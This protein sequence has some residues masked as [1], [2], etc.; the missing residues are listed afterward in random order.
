[1]SDDARSFLRS[2]SL[3]KVLLPV[4]IGL[5]ITAVL[6]FR[7][8]D[9]SALNS[10]TWT[11]ASTLWI[12]LAFGSVVVRDYAYMVRI[13]HLTERSLSW[14]RSFVVIM[15]WEF[16]SALAPGLIGGGFLFAIFILSRE[17]VDAGRSITVITF[18]SFL[19][20]IF[21]AVMAP[22]MVLLV[23]QDALFSGVGVGTS[24]WG[25]SVYVAFWAVYIII[26]AYKL[27]VAY[28]LFI[29]P[30]IVK[31]WLVGLFSIPVLKRWRRNAVT[32]GDQ[33]ITAATGLRSK[34]WSYW[35]PAL[36]ATF[37]SWTARYSIVNCLVH[38]FRD[39]QSVD[40]LL[41]FGKQVIMGILV[42]VSP[43]P[44]GSGLAEFLFN[45]L[46]GMFIPLGLAPALALLWRLISYYPYILAGAILLP[47][48][49][50]RN[51]LHLGKGGPTS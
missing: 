14:W 4:F 12:T 46:L 43:T 22:L 1:M 11:W 48:W 7:N 23:G 2:F 42:L 5:G 29:N 10:V 36:L 47:R 51:L 21:L 28:A 32:T 45:D 18:T 19:D 41:L 34:R 49:I 3:G 9:L 8:S 17:G 20:G 50:R 40:D 37:A 26:L 6:I 24:V 35:W 13:R 44:G 25:S 33:L 30:V 27:F 38:A 39:G 16:S 15:L 31:R